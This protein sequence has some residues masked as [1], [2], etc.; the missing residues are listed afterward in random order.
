M[1]APVRQFGPFISTAARLELLAAM[2]EAPGTTCAFEATLSRTGSAPQ[3]TQARFAARGPAGVPPVLPHDFAAGSVCLVAYPV[4][5]V[6]PSRADLDALRSFFAST[7]RSV[8]YAVTNVDGSQLIMIR[9]P[10][11]TVAL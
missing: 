5:E 8:G 2:Q 6:T 3:I 1:T 7:T 4:P 11:G 9:Y 10:Y